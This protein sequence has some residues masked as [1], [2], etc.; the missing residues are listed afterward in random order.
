[1][2]HER[3]ARRGRGIK[4]RKGP[5]SGFILLALAIGMLVM[6][7]ILGLCIDLGRLYVTKNE[8]QSYVDAATMAANHELD[9]TDDG[10]ARARQVAQ[11]YPNRW[12]FA[13]QTVSLPVVSFAKVVAGPFVLTPPSPPKDY[14]YVRVEANGNLPLYFMSVFSAGQSQAGP[15]PALWLSF[16]MRTASVGADSSAGQ[17]KRTTFFE[18]LLPY[19][20]DAHLDPGRAPVTNP[21]FTRVDPFNFEIGKQYTL[22]WPPPGQRDKPQSWCH[23]DKDAHFVTP[24]SAEQRGFIDIGDQ[25]GSG[26]SSYLR[27]AIV[28][29]VQTHALTVGDPIVNVNGNRGTESDALQERVNQDT[30]PSSQ[31][32]SQ[33]TSNK[34]SGQRIGNGRRVVFVPVNNPYD[35]DRIVDFAAFFLPV[36]NKVCGTS[37][38][39]PCCAEYIGPGLMFGAPSASQD[40]GV[41]QTKLLK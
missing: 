9:G 8:L 6:I 19:S 26:G 31:T 30:D 32:F 37:N 10:V 39:D 21:G 17:F 15:P 3:H 12:N 4:L 1:M 23:G 20:P 13:T 38:V 11:T 7:G 27:Q 14:K 18:N 22:R 28:S 24:S 25:S 2:K 41:F 34:N 5:R 40:A 33:Y 29:N 16:Q 35:G 36:A